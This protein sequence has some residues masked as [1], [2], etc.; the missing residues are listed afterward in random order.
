MHFGKKK[1]MLRVKMIK[2]SEVVSCFDRGWEISAIFVNQVIGSLSKRV[3]SAITQRWKY[4]MV[5]HVSV[6]ILKH[7]TICIR[8]SSYFHVRHMDEHVITTK[9]E[10][11]TFP[12]ERGNIF[13]YVYSMN[14]CKIWN[15]TT[16]LFRLND[17][18]QGW[19]SVLV[20]PKPWTIRS[21]ID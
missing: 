8:F 9:R 16:H 7:T 3:E 6:T 5:T 10:P 4:G 2:L 1:I 21:Q 20:W 12:E 14:M 13:L 17:L 15:R 19:A 18:P 11:N